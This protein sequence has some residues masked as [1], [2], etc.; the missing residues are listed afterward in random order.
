MRG[1]DNLN[2]APSELFAISA[3][4]DIALFERCFTTI[5][6]LNTRRI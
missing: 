6:S 4:F 2:F 5:S 1:V 3:D